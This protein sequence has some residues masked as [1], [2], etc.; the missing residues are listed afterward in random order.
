MSGDQLQEIRMRLGLSPAEFGRALG[1]RGRDLTVHVAVHRLEKG[2]RPIRT[3]LARL[4]LLLDVS[5]AARRL[6]RKWAG[7]P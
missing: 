4:A 6:A 3:P 2:D 7:N 5:P 1:Y